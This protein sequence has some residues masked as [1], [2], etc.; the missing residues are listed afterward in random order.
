M[1]GRGVLGRLRDLMGDGASDRRYLLGKGGL[2]LSARVLGVVLVLGWSIMLTRIMGPTDYGRYVYVM[3]AVFF[4]SLVGGLGMPVA[5]SYYIQRYIRT[6]GWRM[7]GYLWTAFSITILGPSLTTLGVWA[8][9]R[10]YGGTMFDGFTLVGVLVFG[11]GTA[12]VTLLTYA[13]RALEESTFSAFCEQVWQKIASFIFI[14]GVFLVGASLSPEVALAASTFGAWLAALPLLRVVWR[15]AMAGR[16]SATSRQVKRLLPLWMRRSMIMMITPLYFIVLSE[17]DVLM[18]GAITTPAM[19]AIYHVARR[20][21]ILVRFVQIAVVGVGMHRFAAAH[22]D[23]DGKRLQDLLDSMT[24][25]AL[26]PA[27]IGWVSFLVL[28]PFLLSL[29]GPE[30]KAGY[31]ALMLLATAGVYDIAMG[32]STELLMMTG[33]EKIVGMVNIGA[34]VLNILANFLLIPSL[35]FEGAALATLLCVLLWK[36]SLAWVAW[37]RLGVITPVLLRLPILLS[38]FRAARG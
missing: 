29:F 4:S 36:G 6:R 21:A 24:L 11:V 12:A 5:T 9:V 10:L 1:T 30:M 37:R 16:P 28:G 23:Q 35:Q 25:I 19:V 17:T 8:A 38:Q 18:L 27:L 31:V 33:Q 3:S 14:A 2:D 20:V 15:K 13:N 7:A 26:V 22:M 34:G 32:P